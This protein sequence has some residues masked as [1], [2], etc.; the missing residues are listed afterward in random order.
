[1]KNQ[2]LQEKFFLLGKTFAKKAVNELD[3]EK[4]RSFAA[5]H[6]LR[7][8]HEGGV[9]N[10]DLFIK[11]QLIDDIAWHFGDLGPEIKFY[12]ENGFSDEEIMEVIGEGLFLE[13]IRDNE[14]F[15]QREAPE[16]C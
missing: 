16:A 15:K 3:I 7:G 1:M 6:Y 12:R 5:E 14:A 11:E 10:Q 13:F 8:M 9:L 4:L 2:K